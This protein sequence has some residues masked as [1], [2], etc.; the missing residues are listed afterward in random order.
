MP[1]PRT[2]IRPETAAGEPQP[3]PVF[4]RLMTALPDGLLGLMFAY[5]A[6]NLAS[7]A[8]LDQWVAAIIP[9]W[10]GIDA[11]MLLLIACLEAILLWPQLT[12]VDIATRVLKRPSPVIVV[13]VAL[14]GAAWA[15]TFFDRHLP[16]FNPAYFL[17]VSAPILLAVWQRVQMLWSLPGKPLLD[18][19]RARAIMGGRFTIAL[20]V[21]VPFA[22][23]ELGR[24]VLAIATGTDWGGSALSG[25]HPAPY[26]VAALYFLLASFDHWRV[27]GVA[28]ANRPLP[29]LG[30]DFIEVNRIDDSF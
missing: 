27:G 15:L 28:F 21:S 7:Q 26:I 30:W 10:V 11:Q 17:T 29:F 6:I 14:L 2:P 25:W 19:R 13:L 12:L 5:P 3:L 16:Q 18:R 24:S 20:A 8:Q 4:Y 1:L 22:I 9:L 23:F